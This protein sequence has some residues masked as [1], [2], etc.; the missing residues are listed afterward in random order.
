MKKLNR[1]GFTLVELLAIIVILAV[2][3]VVAIPPILDAMDNSKRKSLE[4]SAKSVASGWSNNIAAA[5]LD[6]SSVKTEEAP[7]YLNWGGG[8]TGSDGYKCLTE[9]D[10][11]VLGMDTKQYVFSIDGADTGLNP[12]AP[13]CSMAK[14]DGTAVTVV[15]VVNSDHQMYLADAAK[16]VDGKSHMWASSDGSNSWD[17]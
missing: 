6:P 17:D 7:V 3:L 9:T 4:N 15:L 5:L 1:K 8:T 2:I 11:A 14:V 16:T 13:K 10:A 12:A